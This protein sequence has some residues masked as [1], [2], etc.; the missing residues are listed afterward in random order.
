VSNKILVYGTL[1]VGQG[2]YHTFGLNY[3]TTHLG[4]VRIPGS[5][6]HLG[7]FPGVVLDGNEEGV[8]CDVLEITDAAAAPE[9]VRRLD[10][11]EGYRTD[12]PDNSLY[13]RREVTA[14][15]FGQASIYEINR[16]MDERP[17]IN[18]GDWLARD[19]A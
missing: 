4:Q 11:Y 7:G 15:E 6:Y 10:A 2:A 19:A 8:L 3:S 12:S 17:R 1:R 13:L 9:V 14:G 16:N 18:G 5:M